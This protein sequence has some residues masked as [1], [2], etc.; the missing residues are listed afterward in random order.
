MSDKINLNYVLLFPQNFQCLKV[1]LFFCAETL[2]MHLN[3]IIAQLIR[4]TAVVHSFTIDVV[5]FAAEL[6]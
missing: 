6:L 2:F 5:V 4:V 1:Q 3:K